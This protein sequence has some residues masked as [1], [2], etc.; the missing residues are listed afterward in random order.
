MFPVV[1][2]LTTCSFGLC[3]SYTPR[4]PTGKPKIGISPTGR[5]VA[6]VAPSFLSR[7]LPILRR[8]RAKFRVPH[9]GDTPLRSFSVPTRRS[10]LRLETRIYSGIYWQ[11]DA[12][13]GQTLG[14]AVGGYVVQNF[15]QA[16]H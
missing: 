15:L 1:L 8:L 6:D 11:W 9:P 7:L 2:R 16:N 13:A 3:Q 12:T 10:P 5:T 14:T 4:P